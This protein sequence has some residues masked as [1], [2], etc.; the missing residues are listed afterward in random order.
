MYSIYLAVPAIHHTGGIGGICEIKVTIKNQP[1]A[2]PHNLS[3]HWG[4][5]PL[6]SPL[7]LKKYSVMERILFIYLFILPIIH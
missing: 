3:L 1:I 6:A 2:F 7:F 4:T 5:F